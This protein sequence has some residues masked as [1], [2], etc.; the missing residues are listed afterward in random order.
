MNLFV[1][2]RLGAIVALTAF[3]AFGAGARASE[4]PIYFSFSADLPRGSITASGI[5]ETQP[6]GGGVYEATSVMS[7]GIDFVPAA[8]TTETMSTLSLFPVDGFNGND[9]LLL[10]DGAG[11]FLTFDGISFSA[12]MIGDLIIR[13]RTGGDYAFTTDFAGRGTGTFFATPGPAPGTGLAGFALLILAG[14]AARARGRLARISP[15]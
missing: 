15:H 12:P 8:P 14:A 1:S 5:L 4:T 10:F 9:N 6:L 11:S 3:L 2:S 13:A 7:G